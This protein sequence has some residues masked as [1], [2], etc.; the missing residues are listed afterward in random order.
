M[1]GLEERINQQEGY[2]RPRCLR[3]LGVAES[4]IEN[5]KATIIVIPGAEKDEVAAVDGAHIYNMKP[6][7][8][9][10][11]EG[12]D[13]EAWKHARKNNFL[14][15]HRF[16]FKEDQ[17]SE[18]SPAAGGGEGEEAGKLQRGQSIRRW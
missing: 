17:S 9:K 2:S 18:E 10:I 6:R 5:V 3:L 4:Q 15:N 16:Y 12:S 7:P 8:I 14:Q 13:M 1:A 11:S